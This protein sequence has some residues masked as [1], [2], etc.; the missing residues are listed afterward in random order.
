MRK[1]SFLGLLIALITLAS[2]T[3]RDISVVLNA[4]ND[5]VGVN[6]EW[7][8]AGCTLNIN[9]NYAIEMGVLS[10][11]LDLTTPGE[12]RIVYFEEY[13]S[14][15]Y[16]CL[17]IVKVVDEEPPV[18]ELNAGI[19]TVK[20]GTTW[21]DSG[22]TAID[23]LAEDLTIEVNG[24]VNTNVVGSYEIIYTVTDDYLNT[25]IISRIVNVIE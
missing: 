10:S 23:N 19:D 11:E 20:V 17:R 21:T 13:A 1:L 22:V 24:T 18:V 2:C 9:A 6:E 4:G 15:D 8:D 5:I 12:Y 14:E 7:V 3:P 16:T 25:T